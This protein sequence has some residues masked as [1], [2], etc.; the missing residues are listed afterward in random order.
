MG[1]LRAGIVVGAVAGAVLVSP[2]AAGAAGTGPSLAGRVVAAGAG[3]RV[4][5]AAELRG[6]PAVAQRRLVG[7]VVW[8]DVVA[9]TA[10]LPARLELRGDVTVLARRIAYPA[11]VLHVQAHG[12]T[13][14]LLA[15]EPAAAALEPVVID[16]S[17]AAGLRGF[18]GGPGFSGVPGQ[19]GDRG[20]EG[21]AYECSGGPGYDGGGGEDGGAGT[22]GGDAGGG[23]PAGEIELDIADGSTTR[24]QL[25]ARGG[26][27]G[28]GGDGGPGG[29]GGDGG[30]GGPGGD[31]FP[32]S[33]EFPPCDG[34]YGGA[35]GNGGNGGDGG[36]GGAGGPGGPG[37]TVAVTYPSVG[38]DPGWISVD[39]AGGSGGGGGSGGF[40]GR[41]G[42]GGIGGPGG[43]P[44]YS[45]G[46]DGVPGPGGRTGIPG[47]TTMGSQGSD[48]PPGTSSV[49][50]RG[51]AFSLAVT[52]ATATVEAG[53]AVGTTVSTAGSGKPETIALGASGLPAGAT[54]SFSPAT[55]GT[56]G[57][58]TLKIDTLA[59]V[60]P[61]RYPLTVSGTA[62]SG[63]V[64]RVFVLTVLG[65]VTG[66]SVRDDTDVPIPS[67]NIGIAEIAI[68]GCAIDG[69]V[70]ATVEVHVVHPRRG[71]LYVWLRRPDQLEHPELTE[72]LK[73]FDQA[74][75]TPNL[76][77]T[78]YVRP[79]TV[80]SPDGT[81]GLAVLPVY[82]GAGYIDSWRLT[83]AAA[84][85]APAPGP[86]QLV[87]THSGKC[88][89][90]AGAS[91]ANGAR[92]VQGSCGAGQH[93][94]WAIEPVTEGV[95]HVYRLVA[96]HSG[97]CLRILYAGT[98]EGLPTEQRSCDPPLQALQEWWLLPAGHGT[99]AL[100][101]SYSGRCLG[102][103]AASPA[104]GAPAQQSACLLTDDQRWQLT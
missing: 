7:S 81:W 3:W 82:G 75:Q 83:L 27:G 54:A 88:L 84:A 76:D 19:A 77:A 50:A 17:G 53:N 45:G 35:G 24:Y 86:Y 25:L 46:R 66:C 102:I 47:T 33:A 97:R 59:G 42:Q 69:P 104:D 72:R 80:D 10:E 5:Y 56:G 92:V 34:G 60:H 14:R 67:D 49:T 61:G 43:R 37:G 26:A 31:G 99:Y 9:G 48:G 21:D 55:V 87:A 6:L 41:P 15:V 96:Q 90:V 51:G 63:T 13:L 71:S 85:P 18:P 8:G 103:A 94:R 78:Y 20:R 64:S 73:D 40:P 11:G 44:G 89:T 16:M 100:V 1:R 68:R 29:E 74:D 57:A 70:T 22:G 4:A 28:I 79:S 52:P 98:A 65:P 36:S 101:H 38:Y 58:A 91:P 39:V 23:G 30:W 32:Y 62:P 95:H 2:G 93:Q 12:H